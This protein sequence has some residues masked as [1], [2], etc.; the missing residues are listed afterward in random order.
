MS[1]K[2]RRLLIIGIAVLAVSG[3]AIVAYR[4]FFIKM[5]RVPTGAMANTIVPG[6]CLIAKRLFG[7]VKRGDIIIFRYPS[8]PSV[9]YVSRVVGLPGENILVRDANVYI[10]DHAIA[11]QRVLVKYP[12]DFDF[13]VLEEISSE[14]SGPYR[15]F[16]F[17]R[18]ENLMPAVS[19]E[20][21]FAV[22]EPFQIPA[23]QYFVMGDNRDNSLDSRFQ[24]TVPRELIWGKPSTIYW[25][26]HEDQSHREAIKW[27]RLGRAIQ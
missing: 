20:M 18:G 25:S 14:G 26:S 17:K 8:Q 16:Y 13:G 11:E 5:V 21:K 22:R 12:Y 23:N 1:S 6:D 4:I 24:G 15:V 9:Q 2:Q 3:V 27:E 7:D 19:P 10:N